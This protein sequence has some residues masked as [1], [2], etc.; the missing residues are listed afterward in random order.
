MQM[1]RALQ[2]GT[3]K[4]Y[5]LCPYH[6]DSFA[7]CP[8]LIKTEIPSFCLNQGS[9]IPTNL[10]WSDWENGVTRTIAIAL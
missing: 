2:L 4:L 9:F 10:Q 5:P 1:S 3:S 8:V 7:A 6:D